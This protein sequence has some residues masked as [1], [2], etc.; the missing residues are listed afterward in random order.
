MGVLCILKR[1]AVFAVLC[2]V[3]FDLFIFLMKK[4]F[5]AFRPYWLCQIPEVLIK[6]KYFKVEA[7]Q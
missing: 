2:F 5:A 3:Y 7:L 4:L 6:C 1:T